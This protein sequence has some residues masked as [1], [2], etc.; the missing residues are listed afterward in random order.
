M[1]QSLFEKLRNISLHLTFPTRRAH[2]RAAPRSLFS[3]KYLKARTHAASRLPR[4]ASF[5]YI[6]AARFHSARA[7]PCV[8]MSCAVLA[9]EAV[10]LS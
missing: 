5:S 2:L 10:N 8:A 4:P 6:P 7:A 3:A 9:A 1:L